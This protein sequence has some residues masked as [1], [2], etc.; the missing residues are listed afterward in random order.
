[1]S[2]KNP[3]QI[4]NMMA[5]AVQKKHSQP[6][7]DGDEDDKPAQGS[8]LQKKKAAIAIAEKKKK[9]LPVPSKK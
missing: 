8:N 3:L 4:A 6:M 9:G 5:D 2:K 7:D 1:M